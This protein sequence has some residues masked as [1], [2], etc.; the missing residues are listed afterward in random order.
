MGG[1]SISQPHRMALIASA[2]IL[3][4]QALKR[5]RVASRSYEGSRAA[6]TASFFQTPVKFTASNATGTGLQRTP[7]P[8]KLQL[9]SPPVASPPGAHPV[10]PAVD[11]TPES[12]GYCRLLSVTRGRGEGLRPH[13]GAGWSR[14]HPH[15]HTRSLHSGTM[16]G[17]ACAGACAGAGAVG[18]A[19]RHAQATGLG[20]TETF[21]LF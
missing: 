10:R 16:R 7:A 20:M 11:Q 15:T 13:Y 2:N 18:L 9:R 14:S 4:W 5:R 21:L 3:G 19:A 8:P 12:V 6:A 1:A 17:L